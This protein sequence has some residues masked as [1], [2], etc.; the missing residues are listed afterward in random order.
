MNTNFDAALARC[1]DP[2][3]G[4]TMTAA[5]F[6]AVVDGKTVC[7]ATDAKKMLV[8]DDP[9]NGYYGNAFPNALEIIRKCCHPPT[10]RVTRE[11]LIAWAGKD[12][13]KPCDKC[14]KG[15]IGRRKCEHCDEGYVECDL[16]HEH[17]CEHCDGEGAT[18]KPCDACNG[19]GRL[20]DAIV[21][22]SIPD[23]AITVDAHLIGGLFDLLP[24]DE[25]GICRESPKM[26]EGT[27]MVAFHGPG[28]MLIV[29][30]LHRESKQIPLPPPARE[31]LGER[32]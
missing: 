30:P 6:S 24:G 4:R 7:V 18:G 20:N 8:V 15:L 21:S 17:E 28:W 9:D 19:T 29:M 11:A 3:D 25:I 27:G 32:T 22:I 14:D 1:T 5:P 12:Y 2:R 26:P 31:L 16:G 23:L 13:R 10:H